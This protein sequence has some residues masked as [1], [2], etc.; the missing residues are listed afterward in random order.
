[1]ITKLLIHQA[2]VDSVVVTDEESTLNQ[3]RI[4]ESMGNDNAKRMEKSVNEIED[5]AERTCAIN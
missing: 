3:R 2:F 4:L 5:G 1:M